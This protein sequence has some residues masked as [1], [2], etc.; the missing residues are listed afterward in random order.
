MTEKQE[1]S[2]IL[3]TGGAG[4]IGSHLAERLLRTTNA[5]LTLVDNFDDFYDPAVKRAN[6]A[7]LRED[8]RV[9]VVEADIL[10]GARLDEVVA[11]RRVD[12]VVHLAAKAGVRPSIEDPIAYQRVNVEGTY[13]VLEAV[14][15]AGVRKLVFGSSSSV[16]G[17]RSDPPFAETDSVT[18]PASPYAATKVAGECAAYTYSH[19]YGIDTVCLRFFTVYGPRQRPDLAIHKFAA[20]LVAGAPIP[21]FG[22]GHTARD[23]TFVED[24][25][26]CIERALAYSATPFEVV[27][28]GGERPVELL[29]LVR[30][31]GSA[32]GVTPEIEWL[33]D[34]PGDVPLTCADGAKARRL[35]GFEP[36]VPFAEGIVR[37][38][39]WFLEQ[40][41]AGGETQQR[42]AL[43]AG[44]RD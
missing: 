12:A 33:P 19:L 26:E 18:L 41:K 40:R 2:S 29:D 17:S 36:R 21:L 5:R 39:R 1:T 31:L 13:R 3:V 16:Y 24:V 30:E 11:A 27:N 22:D 23:Y 44:E 7:A 35:F 28:V 8:P 37:F 34:Q 43:I 14:R 10:D 9:E 6:L 4:F 32:L 25:V 15:K 42:S 20:R 38:A